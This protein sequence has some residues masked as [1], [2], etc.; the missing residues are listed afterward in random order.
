M[1]TYEELRT[2]FGHNEL[3]NRVEVACIVAAETIRTEA[4]G[5]EN[6]VNRLAWAKTA[7]ANPKAS[8]GQMLMAL[9]AGN[10]D[11]T[12]ENIIA[13]TDAALQTLVDA[14]VDIFADGS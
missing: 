1:A 5:T 7:F 9:L 3:K 13:V 6:H 14:A 12:V 8:A 2:L 10:L 4:E 11:S